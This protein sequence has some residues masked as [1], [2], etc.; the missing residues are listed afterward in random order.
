MKTIVINERGIRILED[1]EI[2]NQGLFSEEKDIPQE[3]KELLSIYENSEVVTLK[4]QMD[5][6]KENEKRVKEIIKECGWSLKER[7][8]L[9]KK[10]IKIIVVI[11][12]CEIFLGGTVFFKKYLLK[13]Q[14][15]NLKIE[16]SDYK[17]RV[18]LLDRELKELDKIEEGEISFKKSEI[19][20]YLFSISELCKKSDIY[21]E[22]IEI[23]EKRIYLSGYGDRIENIF[24]L[25]RYSLMDGQVSESKFDFI[26]KEG[27]LLYFLMELEID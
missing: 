12:F 25:K 7:K 22:K 6:E 21:L 1:G 15:Q 13:K 14:N 19:A 4:I 18:I 23:R 11:F 26:K 20:E 27:E 16:S 24:N 3:L 9:D 10:I 8:V 2:I 5:M 17:K